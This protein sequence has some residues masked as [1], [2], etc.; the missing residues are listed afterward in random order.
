MNSLA[1]TLGMFQT[2]KFIDSVSYNSVSD[3]YQCTKA[4]LKFEIFQNKNQL[5]I[6]RGDSAYVYILKSGLDAPLIVSRFVSSTSHEFLF[7]NLFSSLAIKNRKRYDDVCI[8]PCAVY[9]DGV[10]YKD[11]DG[12]RWIHQ[13]EGKVS[14]LF[15]DA[16]YQK[17]EE[18]KFL[19]LP[20]LKPYESSIFKS[21]VGAGDLVS[22]ETALLAFRSLFSDVQVTNS[23][24]EK[25]KYSSVAF[26]G[27]V[28]KFKEY[29]K[30]A[31]PI[32]CSINGNILWS[33]LRSKFGLM[34]SLKKFDKIYLKVL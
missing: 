33:K 28:Y 14:L 8:V 13:C 7:S 6:T 26:G 2:Q 1:Q 12:R 22:D 3:S 10:M 19:A 34:E 30:N 20:E 4:G 11:I 25:S 23:L 27:E 9:S 31:E 21:S 17:N 32:F 15:Y 16:V 29:V 18:Y 5:T 24:T